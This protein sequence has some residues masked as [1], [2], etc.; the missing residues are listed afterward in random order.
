MRIP[1]DESAKLV[2]SGSD[3]EE[4]VKKKRAKLGFFDDSDSDV[5]FGDY[6]HYGGNNTCCFLFSVL[7]SA[8]FT[9]QR[10]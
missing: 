7:G 10:L 8:Y 3:Y 9:S 4:D 6:V 1:D 5:D 2:D